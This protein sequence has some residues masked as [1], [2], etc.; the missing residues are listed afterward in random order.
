MKI[1]IKEKGTFHKQFIIHKG[2]LSKEEYQSMDEGLIDF[3]DFLRQWFL[4]VEVEYDY[5]IKDYKNSFTLGNTLLL[6]Y[7]THL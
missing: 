3:F 7:N 1:E 5:R 6:D 4:P 2:G